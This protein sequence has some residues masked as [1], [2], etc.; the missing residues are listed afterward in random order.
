V[1]R[2]RCR[3]ELAAAA[4]PILHEWQM[5]P[6]GAT[7]IDFDTESLSQHGVLERQMVV[8]LQQELSIKNLTWRTPLTELGIDSLKGVELVNTLSVAFDHTFPATSML[9]HPTVA[10][11]ARLIRN[12]LLGIDTGPRPGIG[13]CTAEEIHNLDGYELAEVLRLRIDAVLDGDRS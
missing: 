3:D 1:Q 2:A 10:S 12:T 6:A 9:D 13:I 4:L 11:L 5:S 8:W 7:P